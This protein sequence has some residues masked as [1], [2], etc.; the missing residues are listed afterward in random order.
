M[1]DI[2]KQKTKNMKFFENTII[3]NKLIPLNEDKVYLYSF[4]DRNKNEIVDNIDNYLKNDI[5]NIKQLHHNTYYF[6]IENTWN[7]N[8]HHCLNETVL[9]MDIYMKYLNRF[10]NIRILLKRINYSN[11]FQPFIDML[12]QTKITYIDNEKLIKGNFIFV[13]PYSPYDVNIRKV[14]ETFSIHNRPIIS[15]IINKANEKYK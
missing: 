6:V 9:L 14:K 8:F 13:L 4:L 10:S 5:E 15:Y 3:N 7:S 12:P 11:F 2:L 1:E